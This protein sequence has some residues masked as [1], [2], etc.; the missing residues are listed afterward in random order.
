[1]AAV[2]KDHRWNGLE[3]RNEFSHNPEAQ[4]SEVKG[5]IGLVPSRGSAGE[6]VPGPPLSWLPGAAC[7][8]FACSCITSVS[9]SV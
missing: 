6:S 2:T 3:N 1:M 9:A 7:F 5:L 4:R 8:A